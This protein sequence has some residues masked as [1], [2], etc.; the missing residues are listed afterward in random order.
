ME[1]VESMTGDR[2]MLLGFPSI[3]NNTR[4]YTRQGREEEME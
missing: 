2:L 1:C 4:C 3:S